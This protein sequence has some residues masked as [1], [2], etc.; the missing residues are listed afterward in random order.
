M[1]TKN[2]SPRIEESWKAALA[3]EFNKPYFAVL[4]AFLVSEKEAG[5]TIYPPGKY[6]FNAFDSTPFNDVKVVIIGQDPYHGP[7]QAHG[8][9]FSVQKGVVTPPSLRNM[10]KEIKDDLGM[11][12]PSHGYLQHWADQGVL[13]LNSILT[14]R[15]HQAASHRNKGWEEFTDA[16]IHKLNA[17]RE[18]LVFLLWGGFAK[19]KS[20][21][22]NPAKHLILKAAHPSPLSAN[23]GWFGSKHFSQTNAY[24]EAHGIPPIDWSVR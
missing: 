9:C 16:A 4:K 5:Q 20:S 14:V 24:L 6:I 8:L 22:I 1:A 19:K 17:E 11:P 7:G 18:N 3:D 12:V 15:A 2:V 23:N 13:L 21:M 10:Y